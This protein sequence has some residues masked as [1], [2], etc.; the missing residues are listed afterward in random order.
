M[1]P[2]QKEITTHLTLDSVGGRVLYRTFIQRQFFSTGDLIVT[3]EAVS[4]SSTGLT[5]EQTGL[6]HESTTEPVFIL[7]TSS[8]PETSSLEL[9]IRSRLPMS[10]IDLS[11][12]LWWPA[13]SSP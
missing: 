5:I 7:A 4:A 3:D 11:L 1:G 8:V 10:V 13:L 9:I 12:P 2:S 6:Q